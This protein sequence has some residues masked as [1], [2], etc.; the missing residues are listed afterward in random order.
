MKMKRR[1]FLKMAGATG[2]VIPS[3]GWLPASAQSAGYTGRILINVFA[4][5]GL[6]QSSWADPREMDKRQNSWAVTTPAGVAGNIRYAPIASNKT[7]FD[8]Y[9]TNMLVLNGVDGE[10]NGHDE[11]AM[12]QATG[13]LDMG[14]PNV[15]ELFASVYGGGLPLNYLST[16][17]YR[18]SVGL[19][20]ATPM[21]DANTFRALT[22]PNSVSATSVYMKQADLNRTQ[23]ARAER[24]RV[25]QAR[26]DTLPRWKTV[27]GQFIG[28]ADSRA[29]MDRVAAVTPATFDQFQQA[30]IGLLAATAGITSTIQLNTGG[31]DAHSDID[32]NYAGALPRL[33]DMVDYIWQKSAA[34][35]IDNRIFVR[36]FSDLGRTPLINSGNGKDHWERNTMIL[37]EKA[38][39]WGN[40]VFGASGPQHQQLKI[41]TATGAVDPANGVVI[42]PRHVHAALRKYLNIETTDPR[43]N[44][45]VPAN[46]MF[47]FFNPNAKT[48]YP[49]L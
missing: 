8:K 25:L 5:G 12:V 45:K 9:F 40:R 2:L 11:G 43:F 28:S 46:E 7:F 39:A 33:T 20:A 36:I 38:P 18:T 42:R 16:G 30:N 19:V 3:W 21:P 23:A 48:G 15:S 47:D 34:L 1:N 14:Y 49:N 44:L 37:M 24:M 10:T 26:A 4:E 31:F 35:G 32:N 27:A 41:N 29:L 13:K 6:D 22:S 17:G